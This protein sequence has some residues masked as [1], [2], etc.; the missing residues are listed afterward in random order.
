M[1]TPHN[2][3]PHSNP[4]KQNNL[5]HKKHFAYLPPPTCYSS[6]RYKKQPLVL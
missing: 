1:S 2:H 5:H 3:H 6:Y 4:H